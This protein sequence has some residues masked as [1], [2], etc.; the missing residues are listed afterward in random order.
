MRTH[1]HVH[2]LANS[3]YASINNMV[4]EAEAVKNESLWQMA[5]KPVDIMQLPA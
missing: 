4:V 3:H 2:H 1:S 5:N